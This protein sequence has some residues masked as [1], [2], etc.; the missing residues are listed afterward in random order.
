MLNHSHT[1]VDDPWLYSLPPLA[2]VF[3]LLLVAL[4]Q[5]ALGY[6]LCSLALRKIKDMERKLALGL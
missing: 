3:P 5:L 6:V 4:A 2:R 1:L